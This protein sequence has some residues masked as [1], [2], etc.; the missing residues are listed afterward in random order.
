MRYFRCEAGDQAYEQARLALDAAWGHPNSETK[1][2]T[3][4]DQAAVAPRD[5]QGRIV[6]AVNNEFCEYPAAQQM[7]ASMTEQG[8]VTEITE[9][10]YRAAVESPSPVS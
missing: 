4:I 3:C 7:L 10:E 1:T 2:V 8:A 6:L 5:A 9:A